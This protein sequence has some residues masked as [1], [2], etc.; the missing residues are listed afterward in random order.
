MTGAGRH[1]ARDPSTPLGARSVSDWRISTEL[2]Q[3]PIFKPMRPSKT[4]I[5]Y[6]ES[7]SGTL[8]RPA[9]VGRVTFSKTGKSLS[10]RGRT[11]QSLRGRGFKGNYFDV[12]TAEEFWTSGLRK[13]GEDRLYADSKHDLLVWAHAEFGADF[14]SMRLSAYAPGEAAFPNVQGNYQSLTVDAIL[15]AV[16]EG[17][18]DDG[19]IR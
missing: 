12:E 8:T 1:L 10:Y 9:R 13:D 6:I 11:F 16:A 3:A 5:M 15:R 19:G 7:K 18:W 4:R 17:A 2:P 14:A